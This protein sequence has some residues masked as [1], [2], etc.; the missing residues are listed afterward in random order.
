M[1]LDN[2]LLCDNKLTVF[3]MGP[4]GH[5]NVCVTCMLRLRYILEDEECPVCRADLDEI[6]ISDD[7]SLAWEFFNKKLKKKCEE[8]PEDDTVYYH[9]EA[10][11]QASLQHR[12][13]NCFYPNCPSYK[14][15]FPNRA[16]L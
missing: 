11:K 10:S 15:Q 3:A 4:C 2:C 16:S 7:K 5:K 13:L 6:V 9:N 8:D 14:Q 12:T 1:S